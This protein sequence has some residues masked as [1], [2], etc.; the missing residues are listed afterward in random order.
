M[1]SCMRTSCG[2]TLIAAFLCLLPVAH[3][4]DE[5]HF[6]SSEDLRHIR[7]I[8][9]PRLSADGRSVL[10]QIADS[11]ADGGKSHIWL[12]DVQ[13]NTARQLTY[14]PAADKRG[15]NSAEWMPDGNS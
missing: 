11:T 13:Q 4:A 1:L 9:Q 12:V 3:A 10:I 5:N 7:S 2:C 14:S 15:E 6:P 8:S